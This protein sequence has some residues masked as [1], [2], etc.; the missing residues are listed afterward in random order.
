MFECV[1]CVVLMTGIRGKILF[2]KVLVLQRGKGLITCLNRN[3]QP[4]GLFRHDI[5]SVRA[6]QHKHV[7]A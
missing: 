2:A 4:T 3:D 1:G 5:R 7:Q 6:G